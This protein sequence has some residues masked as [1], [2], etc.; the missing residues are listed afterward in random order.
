MLESVNVSVKTYILYLSNT[1]STNDMSF[2]CFWPD[3]VT[4]SENVFKNRN[5]QKTALNYFKLIN[6]L[7]E[8]TVVPIAFIII[9][10]KSNA[11]LNLWSMKKLAPMSHARSPTF[12]TFA[13][14]YLPC[15]QH[16]QMKLCAISSSPSSSSMVSKAWCHQLCANKC[17]HWYHN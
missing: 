5:I 8:K 2:G 10:Q 17:S 12:H 9:G 4:F 16:I 13:R 11:I 14:S 6:I 15:S 7:F 1:G 3:E